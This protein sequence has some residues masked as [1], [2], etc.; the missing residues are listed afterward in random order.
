[1]LHEW[2]I[3]FWVGSAIGA[4]IGYFVGVLVASNKRGNDHDR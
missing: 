1:M 4:V 3:I 2:A